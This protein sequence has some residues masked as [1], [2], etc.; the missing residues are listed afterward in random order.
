MGRIKAEIPPGDLISVQVSFD[1]GWRARVNGVEQRIVEDALG[2]MVI[3]P[4][5]SGSCTI[6]LSFEDDVEMRIA[7]VLQVMCILACLLLWLS[8]IRTP[9]ASVIPW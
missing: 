8:A 9:T 6:D 3:D 5:C 4:Q 7:R 2:M 1:K